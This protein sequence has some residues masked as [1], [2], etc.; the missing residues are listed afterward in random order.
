MKILWPQP[1]LARLLGVRPLV[2]HPRQLIFSPFALMTGSIWLML[3]VAGGHKGIALA[4]AVPAA[5]FFGAFQALY[6]AGGGATQ[7]SMRGFSICAAAM[8]GVETVII[9]ILRAL[10]S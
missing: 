6:K 4:I 2:I 8:C 1:W 3:F 9:L 5:L 7:L 10:G